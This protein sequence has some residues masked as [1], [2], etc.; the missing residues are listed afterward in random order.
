MIFENETQRKFLLELMSQTNYPGN[1]L[2]LAYEIK[3]AI[4]QATV[5]D[6]E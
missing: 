5:K 3:Q 1:I 4:I 2:D 6:G